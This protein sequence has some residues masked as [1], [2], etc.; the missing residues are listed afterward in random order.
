MAEPLYEIRSLG[1]YSL[2]ILVDPGFAC[3]ALGGPGPSGLADTS[4]NHRTTPPAW[5]HN[6]FWFFGYPDFTGTS[7]SA[8]PALDVRGAAL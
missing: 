8:R 4:S 1:D 2:F 5:T 6:D 3:G 7:R